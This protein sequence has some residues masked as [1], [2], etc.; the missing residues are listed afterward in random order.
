MPM[1]GV[2]PQKRP[3]VVD[4]VYNSPGPSWSTRSLLD[5]KEVDRREH[6]LRRPEGVR[7][8]TGTDPVSTLKRALDNVRPTLEVKSAAS[9]ARPTRSP[10][11]SAG[12]RH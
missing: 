4:P 10:S 1:Q 8:K 7:E 9:V 3:L 11:R 5:G 2:P 6:R 12:P